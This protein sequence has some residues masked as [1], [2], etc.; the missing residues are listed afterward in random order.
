MKLRFAQNCFFLSNFVCFYKNPGIQYVTFLNEN[1][2]VPK[3]GILTP[4]SF[5]VKLKLEHSNSLHNQTFQK[6][7]G[8]LS[9]S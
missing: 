6:I 8:L 5:P 1:A 9:S 3:L 4:L 2:T 7:Y